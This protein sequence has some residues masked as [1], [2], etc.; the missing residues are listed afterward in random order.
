MHPMLTIAV[1]AARKAGKLILKSQETPDSV[2]IDRKGDFD[3]AT[4][5]DRATEALI[6]ETIKRSYPDHTI[7]G[8]VRRR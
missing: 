1:R 5:V 7:I 6:T 3:F 4:N 2:K 8:E